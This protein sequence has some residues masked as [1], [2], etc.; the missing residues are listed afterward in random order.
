MAVF[1]GEDV[2]ILWLEK[3]WCADWRVEPGETTDAIVGFYREEVERSR[4]VVAGAAWGT[5]AAKEGHEQT[6]GWILTHMVEEV[7][8]HCGH[9]DILRERIDGATGE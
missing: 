2:P 5:P 6:L 9:A 3:D 1:A 8:R 4:A 7:G